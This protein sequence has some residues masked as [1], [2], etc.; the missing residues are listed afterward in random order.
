MKQKAVILAAG[1]GRRLAPVLRGVPKPLLTLRGGTLLEAVINW[2]KNIPGMDALYISVGYKHREVAEKFRDIMKYSN[3]A[4]GVFRGTG[5]PGTSY[6]LFD[7]NDAFINGRMKTDTL[8]VSTADNIMDADLGAVIREYNRLGKPSVMILPSGYNGD[9]LTGD[10]FLLDAGRRAVAVARDPLRFGR[11]RPGRRILASGIQILNPLRM[12]DVL[13]GKRYCDFPRLWES[14]I[15][16]NEV[17]IS[18]VE[19]IRWG[20]IDTPE[21]YAR[22][23]EQISAGNSAYTR[24]LG[25]EA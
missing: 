9:R 12:Y 23:L 20:H 4:A 17:Y 11:C 21:D 16:S 1:L 7:F 25:R 3:L 14:L 6:W 22:E 19:P 5:M 24:Y 10:Y 8:W 13:G 15:G 18:G 2:M